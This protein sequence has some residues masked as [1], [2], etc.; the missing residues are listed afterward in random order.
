[1]KKYSDTKYFYS[2]E[3]KLT[4]SPGEVTSLEDKMKKLQKHQAFT[5]ELAA[6]RA[7]L[8]E[9]EELAKQLGPEKEVV[10]E[11]QQLREDWRRLEKA[12][13][14]TGIFLLNLQNKINHTKHY[15]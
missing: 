11:L 13:E 3:Y 7:R 4:I 5:A 12:V 9:V 15:S 2:L 14:E 1:M 8:Q 10:Q 6:N